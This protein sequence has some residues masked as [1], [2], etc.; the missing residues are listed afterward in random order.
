MTVMTRAEDAAAL[1]DDD[2]DDDDIPASKAS[3]AGF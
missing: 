1:S 2:G 3:H